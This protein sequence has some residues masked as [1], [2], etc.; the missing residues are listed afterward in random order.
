MAQQSTL[1]SFFSGIP[2]KRKSDS[3]SESKAKYEQKRKPRVFIESWRK[4]FDGIEDSPDRMICSFCTKFPLLA[5]K[6]SSLFTGNTGYRI[7]SVHSHFSSE[8]HEQCSKANYEVQRRENEEHF[9]G[10][11][12]VAI[13]KISEKNSKLL[14]YM[15]NTAYCVMK[16]ELPF[17][18][19]PTMLKL[20]VKNGSDL[21]RL[22]SYQTDKACARFAPFIAD[23]IRDPIKEKIENC[24]ALSIMYDGATDVSISEVEIIYV[25]LLDD[26]N[27]SDFFIAFKS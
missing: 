25:R 24:K 14:V 11:I 10:P 12:D 16:E 20:Q 3:Q 5:D 23:A 2:E 22:K 7:D 19:Y 1:A 21:S 9:E 15:F 17:T 4:E 26:C 6:T 27:T 18:L 13:R 8:K